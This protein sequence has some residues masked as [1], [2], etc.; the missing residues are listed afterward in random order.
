VHIN[1]EETEGGEKLGAESFPGHEV[2]KENETL[3]LSY[4]P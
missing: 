4:A 2:E 1:C 3:S